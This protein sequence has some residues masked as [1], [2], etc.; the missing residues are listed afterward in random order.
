MYISK[1]SILAMAA[2]LLLQP[3]SANQSAAPQEKDA[4]AFTD[5]V[6]AQL[7]DQIRQ[8]IE[9]R[10]LKK[11]LGAFD[12]SRMSG[13]PVFKNQITAWL[14]QYE[15]VRIHCNVL[16]T[17][18]TGAEGSAIVDVEME[19]NSPGDV[20]APVHKHAQLSFVAQKGARGWKFTDVQPRS[21]FS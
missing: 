17:T 2:V 8:G 11:I 6:A 9:S 18:T 3:L 16:E 15:S 13:G 4:S 20:S 7:L 1:C 10:N 19:A 12:L 5:Q 14:N 21:F